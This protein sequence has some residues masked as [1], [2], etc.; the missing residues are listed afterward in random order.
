[1]IYPTSDRSHFNFLVEKLRKKLKSFFVVNLQ[2]DRIGIVKDI[3]VDRQ[4]QLQLIVS[5]K[6]GNLAS[7]LQ[8]NSKQI[9]K[10]EVADKVVAVDFTFVPE[11]IERVTQEPDRELHSSSSQ[12]IMMTGDRLEVATNE[13][14]VRQLE[15]VPPELS[16]PMTSEIDNQANTQLS[17]SQDLSTEEII[18][19][20]AERVVVE[21]K[22][23]KVGEVIVRKEI[24]TR[25]VEVPV[26]YEKLIVEQ[27]NPEHKQIAEINL[28]QETLA[29]R[30][31]NSWGVGEKNQS[32]GELTVTGR[33][34]SPKVASLLLNA[35]ARE[36]QHGCQQIR[37]EIVV[38]SP[39]KQ[40][41]YQEWCD[42][43]SQ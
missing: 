43:C 11:E 5:S 24:E 29:D 20:L 23:R 7:N 28:G 32:V 33:F 12:D 36:R 42:R 26:R 17:S 13:P 40:K 22:K 10:I 2:G 18:K 3:I 1:M 16:V 15:V 25:M 9:R 21:R 35:I 31:L 38:D 19:L 6:V 34:D 39:E 30:K 27:V 8:I 4:Q 41:L 37:V 14:L